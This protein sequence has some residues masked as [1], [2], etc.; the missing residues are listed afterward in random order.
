[1]ESGVELSFTYS[2]HERKPLTLSYRIF[3][4]RMGRDITSK[5]SLGI[6]DADGSWIEAETFPKSDLVSGRSYSF[7]ASA[8]GFSPAVIAV[9]VGPLQTV[10]SLRVSLAPIGGRLSV[11]TSIEGLQLSIDGLDAVVSL[12][13]VRTLQRLSFGDKKSMSLSLPPGRIRLEARAGVRK[14][15]ED[16]VIA[17]GEEL[18]IRIEPGSAA[19]RLKFMKDN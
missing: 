3:D 6:K 17:S 8:P 7:R 1:M 11:T 10:L 19:D 5:A 9:D 4:E 2:G 13:S 15:A 14:A 12:D 16:L 18:R